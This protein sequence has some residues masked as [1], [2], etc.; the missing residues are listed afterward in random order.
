[1][2]QI[3]DFAHNPYKK[4]FNINSSFFIHKEVQ[5]YELSTSVNEYFFGASIL[6]PL[7]NL[8]ILKKSKIKK[9]TKKLFV[10]AS[11]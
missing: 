2:K 3:V 10:D 6:K 1:M 7:I 4:P 5:N 11:L 9:N 8:S